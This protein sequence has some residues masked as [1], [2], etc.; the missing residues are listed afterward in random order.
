MEPYVLGPLV[1]SQISA[2]KAA[3]E[4]FAAV[5]EESSKGRRQGGDG[6]D[7]GG[8]SYGDGSCVDPGASGRAPPQLSQLS[9]L[10]TPPGSCDWSTPYD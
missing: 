8:A 1:A 3:N 5:D 2:A 6:D 7:D 4:D 10:N 9:Q